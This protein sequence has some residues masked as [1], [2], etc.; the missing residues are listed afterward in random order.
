MTVVE[1][2]GLLQLF[3]E[4]V[5]QRQ[6]QE[7]EGRRRP[8][9]Y[10]LPV[11]IGMMLMQRLQERGTQ[12]EAVHQMA[13]G[14]W[15]QWLRD[16]KRV[17]EGKISHNTGG[18]ARACGR[19][20]VS[21]VEQVCDQLLA[22][23]AQRMEAEPDL[24][25]PLLVLDGSS[26]QVEHESGLLE[27]FPPSRNQR[28]SGHWGVIKWVGLHDART[29]IA[30]RPAWGAMYG[31]EAVSEQQL[32]E[33]MLE[34]APAGSVI[35]GD[36]NFGIFSFAYAARQRN[37]PVLFR[38][39]QE[40][41]T[42]VGGGKLPQGEQRIVWHPSRYERARYPELPGEARI[43]GRLM[44]VTRAGFRETL[45][46]FTTLSEPWEKV[47][48][49]YAKRWNIELDLRTLKRTLGLHHVRGK[50]T[51]AVEKELLIA[52][53]AYGL[54]RALMSLAARRAGLSPRQLSFTRAYSLVNA[55]SDKLC[56]TEV[57]QRQQAY[58]RLLE[59]IG[60][61]KLPN[62]SKPRS[63]PRAVWGKGKYYPGNSQRTNA[64]SK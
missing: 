38:L 2:E 54:V 41:A 62:R 9:I 17:R 32:G 46:L 15:D 14:G 49:L 35:V 55:M 13:V 16:C 31:S 60:K 10:T 24:Q 45:Y 5:P 33:K 30:L 6:W 3:A 39:S 51:E 21:V 11:V 25:V 57:Q 20:P 22:E 52:V 59:F 19:I 27:D 7:L 48:S 1:E 63:Y 36:G 61:A 50:S 34:R 12:Q 42:V 58:G 28:G 29:G 44:A 18:Y 43:E 40:R 53:V 8:Q 47:V 37:L 64:Q 23:L 4:V 56:A 26:L